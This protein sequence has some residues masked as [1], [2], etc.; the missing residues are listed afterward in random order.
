[1]Q[2]IFKDSESKKFLTEPVFS[3]IQTQTDLDEAMQSY[4]N[5]PFYEGCSERNN[6][7]FCNVGRD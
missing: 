2:S 5:L 1:M 7:C 4:R 3:F 6:E